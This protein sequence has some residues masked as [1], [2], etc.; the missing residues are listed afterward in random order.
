MGE[1][2]L[3]QGARFRFI[4]EMNDQGRVL[5]SAFESCAGVRTREFDPES[6]KRFIAQSINLE[7]RRKDLAFFENS[8]CAYA[9]VVC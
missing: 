7:D 4:M 9:D 2:F 6:T 5:Y 8:L 1:D 3:W